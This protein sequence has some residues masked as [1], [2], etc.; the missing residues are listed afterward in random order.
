[1]DG[2]SGGIRS[3]SDSVKKKLNTTSNDDLRLGFE[4][5]MGADVESNLKELYF[6]MVVLEFSGSDTIE[7]RLLHCIWSK[8]QDYHEMWWAII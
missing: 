1:M 3:Q 4:G 6:P 5:I 7:K 2:T 8:T